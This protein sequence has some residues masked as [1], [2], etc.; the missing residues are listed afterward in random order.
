MVFDLPGAEVN[1]AWQQRLDI[2]PGGRGPGGPAAIILILDPTS[3]A[4]S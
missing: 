1:L 4:T 3:P 2:R